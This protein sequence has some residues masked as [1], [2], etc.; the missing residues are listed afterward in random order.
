MY[1]LRHLAYNCELY[2]VLEYSP[3]DQS[4]PIRAT[5]NYIGK[6]HRSVH[7]RGLKT[8]WG[9]DCRIDMHKRSIREGIIRYHS[10]YRSTR[11]ASVILEGAVN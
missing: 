9:L 8:Y 7:V 2:V 10:I 11:L 5:D 3:M 4:K 6:F 1:L